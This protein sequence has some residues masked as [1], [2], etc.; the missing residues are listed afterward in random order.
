MSKEV[1]TNTTID[2]LKVNYSVKSKPHVCPVCDGRGYVPPMFYNTIPT[3][4]S[5][6]VTSIK[7]NTCN[8][9]GIVWG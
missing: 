4:S 1:K 5:V 6:N 3:T 9:T 8:G 7:C 2:T